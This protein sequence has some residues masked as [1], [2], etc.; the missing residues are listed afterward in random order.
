MTTEIKTCI[1]CEYKCDTC[2]IDYSEQ[3][4][5]NELQFFTKCQ[6]FNCSGTYVLVSQTEYTYEQE[7]PDIEEIIN[8]E[9]VEE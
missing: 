4:N 9:Q 8:I 7:I 2:S 6:A 5:V 1:K 3:R